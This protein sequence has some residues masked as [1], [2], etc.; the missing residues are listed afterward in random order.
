MLLK[1]NFELLYRRVLFVEN[2]R[3]AEFRRELPVIQIKLKC[4]SVCLLSV[5]QCVCLSVCMLRLGVQVDGFSQLFLEVVGEVQG[6][7][8]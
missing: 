2:T 1:L 4:V 3:T 8:S 5:C 6:S 7:V